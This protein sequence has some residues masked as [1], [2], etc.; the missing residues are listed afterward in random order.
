MTFYHFIT[1]FLSFYVCI[2]NSFCNFAPEFSPAQRMRA[3]MDYCL[4]AP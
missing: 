1:L 4:K 3:H 2:L